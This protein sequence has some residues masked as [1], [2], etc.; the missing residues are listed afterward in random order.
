MATWRAKCWLGS[1]SGFQ[2]LEV[3]ANTYNGAREQL[4]SIYGAQQ[5]IN[6]HQVNS[7]N[8]MITSDMS[9]GAAYVV[10]FEN[11]GK[12]IYALVKGL[13]MLIKYAVRKYKQNRRD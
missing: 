6:L 10:L 4:V 11:I 7:S 9:D 3:Q 8:G 1:N 5:V 2:H 12:L 13:V